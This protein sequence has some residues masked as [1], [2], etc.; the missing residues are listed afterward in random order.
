MTELL[1]QKS[2]YK[3]EVSFRSD[4]ICMDIS[5]VAQTTIIYSLKQITNISL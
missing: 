3:E 1:V 2:A 5:I 4:G